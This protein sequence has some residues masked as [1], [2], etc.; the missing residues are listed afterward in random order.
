MGEAFCVPAP[1]TPGHQ[2]LMGSE[3]LP[4]WGRETCQAEAVLVLRAVLH[5]RGGVTA[6]SSELPALFSGG[7]WVHS[8]VKGV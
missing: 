2:W 3:L 1:L 7:G 5:Q 8:P 6:L 4:E